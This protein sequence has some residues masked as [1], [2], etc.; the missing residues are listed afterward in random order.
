MFAFDRPDR[1]LIVQ[2]PAEMVKEQWWKKVLQNTETD[3][4]IIGESDPQ[5]QI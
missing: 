3:V 4:F 1:G 5:L 2:R